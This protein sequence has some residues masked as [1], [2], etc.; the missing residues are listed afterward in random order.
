MR[1]KQEFIENCKCAYEIFEFIDNVKT[2]VRW[3]FDIAYHHDFENKY[4]AIFKSYTT[5]KYKDYVLSIEGKLV[6]NGWG[7]RVVKKVDGLT[8]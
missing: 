3:R 5:E 1:N 8:K 7:Y 4:T 2:D 6:G